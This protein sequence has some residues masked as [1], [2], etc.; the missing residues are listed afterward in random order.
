MK[1]L[2]F[3]VVL[4]AC[5]A[6]HSQITT[7]IELSNALFKTG[8]NPEWSKPGLDDHDW[9]PIK[10]Q[11]NWEKQGY[12]DYNG[13]GWYRFNFELSSLIKLNSFWPD[14]VRFFLAKM[15][16]ADE[17][18]LNGKLISKTG[19]FPDDPGGYNTQWDRWRDLRIATNDPVLL[20][21]KENVLAIRVYDGGGIGGM[22]G[23]IPGISMLQLKD[24]ASLEYKNKE[25]HFRHQLPEKSPGC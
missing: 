19:R 10:P 1:K 3:L 24:M 20:W 23:G 4:F 7:R 17:V 16:D 2:L 11:Y 18:Y 21:D 9:K 14:S 22:F 8:D 15:D 6:G 5:T 12:A 13:F 25:L